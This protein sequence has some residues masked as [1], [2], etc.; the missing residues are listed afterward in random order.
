MKKLLQCIVGIII[1]LNVAAQ[2]PQKMSFQAVIRNASNNLIINTTVGMRI[3]VLKDS[4]N[5]TAVYVESQT[6]TSNSN[7]LI[8]IAVGTGTIVSGSFSSINWATGVY[9]IKTETDPTGGT[10]YTISGTQQLMTVPYAFYAENSGDTSLWRKNGSSI[11]YNKGK[12][13]IGVASPNSWLELAGTSLNQSTFKA[14][15]YV[16]DNPGDPAIGTIRGLADGGAIF[17]ISKAQGASRNWG[18]I[19]IGVD[20]NLANIF[21]ANGNIGIDIQPQRKL[22]INDV[23]RLE[24]RSTSPSNPSKGDIYFDNSLNKLRVYDGTTWQ[25]CW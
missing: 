17:E 18:L 5:G 15:G 21:G 14:N 11:Y 8:T 22:H 24:P 4:I 12:V 9:F 6:P 2:T 20:G 23:M 19:R 7:G 3:S 10:S 16:T 1:C 25:N 13:G